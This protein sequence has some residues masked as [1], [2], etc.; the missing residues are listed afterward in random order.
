MHIV[1]FYSFKGGTGRSMALV[2]VA[3]EMVKS[4][5]RV[6]VVDFDLEAPGLDTFNLPRPQKNTKGIVDFVL[7][8]LETGQ[9]PD[10]SEFIYKSPI[11]NADGQL[12][13]MP[14]GRPSDDYDSRFKS[15]DWRDLYESREGYLLFEDVKAQWEQLLQPDYVLI[16]SRTGHSDI[17]G[18]CTR[19]LPDTVVLFFFPNEQN[20]RG[21]ETVVRQIRGESLT[22][23]KKNI[24]LHFVMSNVPELDDEE[25]F[26]ANIEVRLKESLKVDNFSAVIHHYESLALLTQS[27]FTLDRPRTKLAEEYRTLTRVIRKDNLEDRDIVLEFLDEMAPHTRSRQVLAGDLEQRIQDIITKHSGD[28]EILMRLAT[29]L[30]RQRRF[31]EALALLEQAGELGASSADFYLTRAE[32]YSLRKK[33]T[34]ALSDVRK[35]L[36]AADATYLEVSA[37]ARLLSQR[38]PDSLIEIVHAPA[39]SRL[40]VIGQ[41]YVATELLG[42]RESLGVAANILGKLVDRS[43]IDP[44]LK[45]QASTDLVL[46]L[47]GQ[48]KYA[49]AISV[50]SQNERRSVSDLD[51]TDSF[52][53]AMAQWGL[54]HNPPLELFRRVVELDQQTSAKTANDYQRLSIALWAVN[55]PDEALSRVGEAWQQMATRPKP[56][57]SGWSYLRLPPDPFLADLNEIQ[58]L[59]EGKPIE[60]RF[61]RE[62]R[63]PQI[64]E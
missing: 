20:R 5:L 56:E 31:D 28:A 11:L 24:K 16:D 54:T 17:S 21:L 55:K 52:N 22:S 30:R 6:L 15:I 33:P 35:L 26:L 36:N 39:F 18:I 41:Y 13:M 7:E 38:D 45:R 53:Y 14:A 44:K 32:L 29:L 58:Q 40:D 8:Y 62:N 34:E 10:V 25:D 47:I 4:G 59:I 43:E 49:T 42:S 37:A 23:R 48:G 3:V 1:T 63:A 46:S 9:S 27:V 51:I 50:I 57:F 61:I 64:E 19:Q 12:W 60:P 2:N